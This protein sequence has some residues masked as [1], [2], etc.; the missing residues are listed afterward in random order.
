MKLSLY[1][2]KDNTIGVFRNPLVY[3]KD[4]D[5]L[6]IELKTSMKGITPEQAKKLSDNSLYFLGSFDNRSGEIVPA[7]DFCFD[8]GPIAKEMAAITTA[9]ESEVA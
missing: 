9:A 7:C 6:I 8:V 1:A 2:Y 4:I 5:S 3:D